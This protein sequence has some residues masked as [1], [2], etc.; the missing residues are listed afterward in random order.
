MLLIGGGGKCWS[1]KWAIIASNFATIIDC[2]YFVE[3]RNNVPFCNKVSLQQL[4]LYCLTYPSES[5]GSILYNQKGLKIS[6]VFRMFLESLSKICNLSNNSFNSIDL[7]NGI[8][9]KNIHCGYEKIS[10]RMSKK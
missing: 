7:F 6:N 9:S 4:L 10:L 8:T 1:I 2:R 3:Q 5:I